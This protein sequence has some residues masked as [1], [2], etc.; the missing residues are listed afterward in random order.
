MFLT[1]TLYPIRVW[2]NKE[3]SEECLYLAFF[4]HPDP[5]GVKYH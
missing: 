1:Q 4:A 2:I 3:A 5:R